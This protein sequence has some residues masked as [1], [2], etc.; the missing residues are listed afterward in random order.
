MPLRHAAQA[1][2]VQRAG[3]LGVQ[4]AARARAPLPREPGQRAALD[5]RR[6]PPRDGSAGVKV[7]DRKA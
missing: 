2:R 3:Q 1:A 4:G 7:G 5:R 6:A